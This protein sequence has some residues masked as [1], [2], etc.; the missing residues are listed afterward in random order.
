MPSKKRLSSDWRSPEAASAQPRFILASSAVSGNSGCWAEPKSSPPCPAGPSS[1]RFGSALFANDEEWA[2]VERLLIH[3][4]SSRPGVRQIILMVG[5]FLPLVV[6]GALVAPFAW[7]PW[8]VG[9]G[10]A[11]AMIAAAFV[12]AYLFWHYQSAVVLEKCYDGLL[13]RQA[14]LRDLDFT[15]APRHCPYLVINATGLNKGE[16]VLFP[17]KEQ[18]PSGADWR[19]LVLSKTAT[20]YFMEKERRNLPM[21][22]STPVARAVAASSAIPGVFAPLK[23]TDAMDQTP[24]PYRDLIWG[25]SG[26]ANSFRAID[27][28]VSDNQGGFLIASICEHLIVSDGSASLKEHIH[29]STWQFWPPGKGVLFRAQDIIFDRVRELG[30]RRLRDWQGLRHRLW[31][32]LTNRGLDDETIDA[33]V[34]GLG[35]TLV[36]YST[37]R[38]DLDH[39]SLV[40]ISALMFHGYTLIDHCIST[41]QPAYSPRLLRL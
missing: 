6:L 19:S 14:R 4:M 28:G 22:S 40:E 1:A 39:F 27:G 8:Y 11:L 33:V 29:P 9:A 15:K 31:K 32:D 5:F 17:T 21:P 23:L 36:S 24:W 41:V 3:V 7:W 37:V 35:R 2:K 34:R 30:Y 13:Y 25:D 10:P 12:L 18:P 16:M 38:T 26:R 20:R